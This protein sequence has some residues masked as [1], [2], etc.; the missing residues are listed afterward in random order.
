[1]VLAVF[2][3]TAVVTIHTHTLPLERTIVSNAGRTVFI[4][5][6]FRTPILP[7]VAQEIVGAVRVIL[8][9]TQ[10]SSHKHLPPELVVLLTEQGLQGSQV[11]ASVG[12]ELVMET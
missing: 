3:L 9:Q 8:E 12:L 5:H 6:A 1:M 4:I 11:V 2:R 10:I 7:D